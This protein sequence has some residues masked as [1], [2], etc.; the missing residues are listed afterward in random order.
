MCKLSVRLE[1][2]SVLSLHSIGVCYRRK[3]M[4]LEATGV[5]VNTISSP[6][7]QNSGLLPGQILEFSL[8]ATKNIRSDG[9]NGFQVLESMTD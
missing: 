1:Y 7:D 4:I 6:R 5:I 9:N 3:R 2:W 8:R